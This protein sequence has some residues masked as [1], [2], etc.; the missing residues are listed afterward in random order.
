MT[1]INCGLVAMFYDI[2]NHV[3]QKPNYPNHPF[4][5]AKILVYAEDLPGLSQF[6]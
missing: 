4:K 5:L 2:N 3:P 1:E 6:P